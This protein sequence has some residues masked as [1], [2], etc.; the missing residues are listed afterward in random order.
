VI[1]LLER[2]ADALEH[3]VCTSCRAGPHLRANLLRQ[4]RWPRGWRVPRCSEALAQRRRCRVSKPLSRRAR[5]E[6]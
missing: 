2:A 4:R 5:H 3:F 6:V 1:A